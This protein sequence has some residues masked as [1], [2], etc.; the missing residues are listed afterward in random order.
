[1]KMTKLTSL[2]LVAVAITMVSTGCRKRPVAVTPLKNS[3]TVVRP[4]EMENLPP[5]DQTGGVI[6]DDL[7]AGTPMN[8]EGWMIDPSQHT[9]DAATLAAHVVHFAFDSSVV[10]SSESANV[11]AV[12]SYLKSNSGVG[13]RIDGHCDERGTDGYNDALGERRASALRETLIGMGVE[14]N[15]V[16]T[17]SLGE[18]M[19]VDPGHNESAWAKN[20][21]GEF[22]LLYRK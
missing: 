11:E 7:N 21:R 5:I 9:E 14:P 1:M 10:Q 13:L 18:S 16:I 20:R 12:A 4:G 15:M 17:R 6:A 2:L 22:I 3:T 8:P 19:P